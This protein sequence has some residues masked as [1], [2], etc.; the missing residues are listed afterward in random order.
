MSAR[1][2]P[3]FPGWRRRA[4]AHTFRF[5]S[6]PSTVHR[7][8]GVGP[9]SVP[10]PLGSPA[11][12]ST[13]DSQVSH[14]HPVSPSRVSG[15]WD[16]VIHPCW[17]LSTRDPTGAR[18]PLRT[19]G[20]AAASLRPRRL[21]RAPWL[22]VTLLADA[23]RGRGSPAAQ[24]CAATV[25]SP[26]EAQSRG[27]RTQP[28]CRPRAARHPRAGPSGGAQN[29]CAGRGRGCYSGPDARGSSL[30][31][32][33]RGSAR[34]P[35]PAPRVSV[36]GPVGP[37]TN[38]PTF[39]PAVSEGAR[40]SCTPILLPGPGMAS[41]WRRGRGPSLPHHPLLPPR[42][43]PP[44]GRRVLPRPRLMTGRKRLGLG[45]AWPGM[46]GAWGVPRGRIITAP[47]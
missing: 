38:A 43:A 10:V 2:R 17:Q 27:A 19:R 24:P 41:P 4:P 7:L 21:G 31:G 45:R 30:P 28:A 22:L 47:S 44:A 40:A 6:A 33:A 37:F 13:C 5:T 32:E 39:Q 36:L 14:R 26:R 18:C 11:S 12:A 34:V 16:P 1:S 20:G 42:G 3:G 8:P 25:H 9:V 46:K 35:E 15:G 23:S 29:S